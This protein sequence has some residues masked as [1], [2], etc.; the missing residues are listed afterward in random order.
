VRILKLHNSP[1]CESNRANV[2]EW[3]RIGPEETIDRLY[4]MFATDL[5]FAA[6]PSRRGRFAYEGINPA[7]ESLLG[8]SSEEIRELDVSACLSREDARSV[9]EALHACLAER[10]EVRIRHRLALGGPR[11]T[12]ETT[13]A[14]I[15]DAATGSM[16]RLIGSHH[17]L[18]EGSVKDAEGIV[19]A[20][21]NVRL[22]SIQEDI[23][24]K[25]ASDLH[26]S[27]CQHL[28]AASLGLMRIRASLGDP[29]SAERLC[30]DI[31]ASIDEALREIRAF[32]YLLYPQDLTIDGLKATIEHYAEGFAARTALEVST[33]IAS[34]VDRLPYEKQRSLLRVVQEALTNVFRHAK[35]TE[36][37]I[38]LEVADGRVRLTIS[39]DGRGMPVATSRPG[40]RAISLGVGI[41]AMRARLQQIGGTLEIRSGPA[42]RRSGTVLCAVFP[43]DFV[44]NRRNRRKATSVITTHTGTQ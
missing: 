5:L 19:D 15:C 39:D 37:E 1:A 11:R 42:M 21:M 16:V 2:G 34:D 3:L 7:F 41:P 22:V 31:D 4:W 23:Q 14:P 40:T 27:T 43:H 25:I 35:A 33:R 12:I 26:D 10:A 44:T 38:V 28:I 24:Q 20:R 32:A 30:N 17:I 8:I 6:R 29:V 18:S 9:C 13:V 36:V